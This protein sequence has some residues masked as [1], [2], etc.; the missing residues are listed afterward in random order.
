MSRF[1]AAG[2]AD[3]GPAGDGR[4]SAAHNPWATAGTTG[5]QQE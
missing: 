4:D 2:A 5:A 3:V 1:G